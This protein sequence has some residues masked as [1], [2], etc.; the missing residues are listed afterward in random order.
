M[1]RFLFLSALLLFAVNGHSQNFQSIDEGPIHEAYAQ[2]ITGMVALDAVPVPPPNPIQERIP[3]QRDNQAIWIPG[4][5]E[6]DADRNDFY[7]VTGTWRRPPP[8]RTWIPGFWLNSEEGWVRVHGFWSDVPES[9]LTFLEIPPPD[10]IDENV[11]NPPGQNYFWLNGYWAFNP[12][13]NEY[14]W[15]EGQWQ[16]LD[17]NWVMVPAHYIWRPQ[18][19]VFVAAYWDAPLDARGD[20]YSPVDIPPGRRE[21]AVYAPAVILQS[22]VIIPR[23]LVYYPDYSCIYYHHHHYHPDFWEH[24][25]GTPPWWGWSTW[26]SYSWSDTWGLWWWYTHPGYPHPH[27]ITP[28]MSQR[29][30]PPQEKLLRM[31]KKTKGPAIITPNGVVKPGK[32]L[33]VIKKEGGKK[34]KFK[35]I[36]P[37]DKKAKAK[38]EELAEPKK[39][40]KPL[41]P[42][43]KEGDKSKTPITK[44][45]IDADVIN[46]IPKG[47]KAAE[48]KMPKIT[49]PKNES[50]IKTPA[51][52]KVPKEIKPPIRKPDS[53][54]KGIQKV[55]DKSKIKTP[56]TIPV[57]DKGGAV[58][59]PPPVKQK[60]IKP[61]DQT[62]SF[63]QER[64]PKVIPQIDQDR[65][66]KVI[67]PQKPPR[68]QRQIQVPQPEML[69]DTSK[70][71]IRDVQRDDDSP[72]MKWQGESQDRGGKRDR[73]GD[74]DDDDDRWKQG[75][76][77]K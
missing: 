2:R 41:I 66:P 3:P 31:F 20:A 26:W 72:K 77:K 4:Y 75:K 14:E 42:S 71:R 74:R 50:E 53:D 76:G 64:V 21:G 6:W 17:P 46:K 30:A 69:Q 49:Y 27:W 32:L 43:G 25:W 16:P 67:T 18:G 51:D 19:Y 70:G 15:L 56:D 44:P 23:L 28:A 73:G 22:V 33:D 47:G 45:V 36:I 11:G 12:T 55:N 5:W 59:I 37:S 8:S 65:G 52:T 29:F 34:G 63:D 7:W 68:E 38:F 48:P 13:K 40:L 39:E 35:P 1:L 9:N 58:V 57:R 62:P 61:I 60:D 54:S 24:Y 10:A